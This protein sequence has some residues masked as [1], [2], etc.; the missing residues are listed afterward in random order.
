MDPS[1]F[2]I[3]AHNYLRVHNLSLVGHVYIKVH[4]ASEVRRILIFKNAHKFQKM[5]YSGIIPVMSIGNKEIL[6]M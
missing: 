2:G 5:S 4:D 6:K 1:S 3:L